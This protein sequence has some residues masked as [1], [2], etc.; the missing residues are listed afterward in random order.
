MAEFPC[1][2]VVGH[3]NQGKSS[4]VSTLAQDDHIAISPV[5][6]TTREAH[7]YRLV[8]KE[9][10]LYE[11]IDT[12]GFQRARQILEWCN[13][14]AHSAA[15][16]P[17]LLSQFVEEHKTDP[18]FADDCAV[19]TPVLAGA[20]IIYVVNSSQPYSAAHDAEL[21]LLSW[22]AQ[23]RLALLNPMG[24]ADQVA[25]TRT[26]WQ[27][28]LQQYFS[29]VRTFNPLRDSFTSQLALIRSL[30][31][32]APDWQSALL[33]GV[34]AL[35]HQRQER[36]DQA[37][38]AVVGYCEQVY[39]FQLQVPLAGPKEQLKARA[40]AQYN[41]ELQRRESRLQRTL[42]RIYGHHHLDW[43]GEWQPLSHRDLTDRREWRAWGLPRRRLAA[44][45]TAAGAASGLAVDAAAGGTSLLLGAALG[46]VIGGLA[47]NFAGRDPVTVQWVEK[48]P[49]YE[50][51]QLG[52]VSNLEF[53]VALFG[54]ALRIWYQVRVRNH[55]DRAALR[56]SGSD[57]NQWL[58]GLASRQQVQWLYWLRKWLKRS[59]T[60]S[61]Q[62]QMKHLI[63][64]IGDQMD[65]L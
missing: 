29:L 32:I 31:E 8:L 14:R 30:A 25:A 7:R 2:A 52:P 26:Q 39:R 55:A 53:A 59:L 46:G 50:H 34:D 43:E 23:P 47:G 13:E 48:I 15:D 54:R 49:G 16:R 51:W 41:A 20:G 35:E 44:L 38:D 1:F 19:L 24:P 62:K 6:G 45:S 27:Q 36:H 57:L 9:R 40:L 56:L 3:P 11:W 63:L 22:T 37:A 21:T 12:P 42:A 28:A 64:S 18:R 17:A 61:E 33:E 4:V 5:S 60:E 58:E 65:S 10:V